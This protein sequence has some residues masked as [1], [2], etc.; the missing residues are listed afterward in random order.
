MQEVGLPGAGKDTWLR[1]HWP[2]LP[3]VSLDALRQELGVSPTDNQGHVIQLARE[4]C[5]EHLRA[6][7]DFAFNATNTTSKMRR[8]WVDLFAEYGARVEIVYLEPRMTEIL[9][10]NKER[11]DAVPES[12]LHRLAEKLEVPGAGEAHQVRLIQGAA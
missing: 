12:V 10:Q 9:R 4:C 1:L 11:E 7:R 2:G 3:V 8:R 6:E 5:R